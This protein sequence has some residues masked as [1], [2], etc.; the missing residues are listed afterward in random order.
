MLSAG[1]KTVP[2][3]GV[4]YIDRLLLLSDEKAGNRADKPGRRMPSLASSGNGVSCWRV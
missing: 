1:D 2:E 4:E 3:E